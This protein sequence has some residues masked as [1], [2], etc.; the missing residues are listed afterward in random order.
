[1]YRK[2]LEK[3]IKKIHSQVLKRSEPSG[4]ESSASVDVLLNNLSLRASLRSDLLAA[5]HAICPLDCPITE[6]D[7]HT[8][9]AHL[10]APAEAAALDNTLTTVKNFFIKLK[11]LILSFFNWSI[12]Y[13]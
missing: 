1:M 7:C 3:Q 9:F 11:T 6:E 4:S 12:V 2:I 10:Y 8:E 13:S 5:D